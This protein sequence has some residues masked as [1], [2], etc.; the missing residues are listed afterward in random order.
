MGVEQASPALHPSPLPVGLWE[1]PEE[2]VPGMDA[3]QEEASQDGSVVA[4]TG[5]CPAGVAG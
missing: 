4:N 5:L 3:P 2:Q 1:Q